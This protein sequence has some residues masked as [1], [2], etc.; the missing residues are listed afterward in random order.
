MPASV[1]KLPLSMLME[2]SGIRELA[3]AAS[4]QLAGSPNPP[5]EVSLPSQ[6]LETDPRLSHEQQ[7]LWYAHQ[8]A[9]TGAAYHIAGAA[10]VR[11]ELDIDALRRALGRVIA[12][13]D[14]LRTTFAN[15]RWRPETRLLDLGE[16]ALRD[17]EWL[18]VENVAGQDDGRWIRGCA[19]GSPAVRPRERTA[20]PASTF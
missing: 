14:A 3:E 7:L 1:V 15:R 17:D 5:L 8:F 2:A 9:P 16:L 10:T 6:Q 11:A 19:T 4:E 18:P 13:Q 12:N 20:F